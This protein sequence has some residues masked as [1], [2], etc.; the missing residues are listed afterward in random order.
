MG[1]APVF[2][3]WGARKEA[4]ATGAAGSEATHRRCHCGN[5]WIAEAVPKCECAPTKQLDR[6]T[7]LFELP[8]F[9]I[10]D[11][12]TQGRFVQ[13]CEHV[14]QC[15]TVGTAGRETE[16]VS[17]PQGSDESTAVLPTE[18]TVLLAVSHNGHCDYLLRIGAAPV[19]VI[20]ERLRGR[21]CGL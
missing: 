7:D 15:S 16:A 1:V 21:G 9:V 11:Q 14:T 12:L 20:H 4:G 6:A 10:A 5:P 19:S 3:G 18:V 8:G 2:R 17:F 13:F